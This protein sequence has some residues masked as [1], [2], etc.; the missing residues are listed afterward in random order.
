[1]RDLAVV[2]VQ[3]VRRAVV[4]FEHRQVLRAEMRVR[5]L[6]R[7]DRKQKRQV[8]V[9]GVQQVQLAEIERIVAGNRGEV[10]VELVVGFENRLPSA[11]VKTPVNSPTSWSKFRL[12][13]A[14]QNNGER[15]VAERLAVA[16]G[17]QAVAEVLDVGLL[18]FVD[19][20][21]AR[22]R[23]RRVVAHLRDKAGLRHIEVAAALV[24]FLAGLVR[25]ERRPLRDDV[26]VG[27][28][29]QQRIEH[30]GAASR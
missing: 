20:H 12:S 28:D 25:R 14:V 30:Q 24:D 13:S 23:L 18:R 21:I 11:L 2:Q 15:E 17:A 26:E 9:V 6:A 3:E 29:L 4:G 8:G 5:L 10:G 27:W 16:Q 1:M 19:Q 22:I 7:Q